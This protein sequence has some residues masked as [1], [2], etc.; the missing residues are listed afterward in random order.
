MHT[1]VEAVSN[2]CSVHGAAY[3]GRSAVCVHTPQ[4]PAC[5]CRRGG[6]DTVSSNTATQGSKQARIVGCQA[7]WG[8][9]VAGEGEGSAVYLSHSLK[10]HTHTHACTHTHTHTHPSHY[11]LCLVVCVHYLR[12]VSRGTTACELGSS[13]QTSFIRVDMR[14]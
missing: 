6:A 14:W 8:R 13:T 2:S 11:P 9:G 12:T 7:W 10:T 1:T 4:T 5:P 3:T